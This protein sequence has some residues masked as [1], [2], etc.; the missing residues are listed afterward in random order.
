D[1][2][3]LA[4]ASF[5]GEARLWDLKTQADIGS[6]FHAGWVSAVAFS[7]DGQLVATASADQTAKLWS[8]SSQKLLRT[9]KGHTDGV[10]SVRFSKDGKSLAT[11]SSDGT[12][13]IWDAAEADEDVLRGHHGAVNRLA[14]S[15]DG[16]LLATGD[17]AG[18]LKVWNL[19][20][21]AEA[22]ELS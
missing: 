19:T 15:P 12:V 5:G 20:N 18:A 9:F 21:R 13:R 14:F 1:K 22:V 10:N 8:S 6:L 17:T 3:M 11:G 4:A 2:R 7:P 16:T